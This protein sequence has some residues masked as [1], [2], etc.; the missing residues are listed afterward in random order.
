MYRADWRRAIHGEF[1]LRVKLFKICDA[2]AA[3]LFAFECY[4]VVGLSAENTARRILLK[5]NSV[6]LNK[7]L[8][9]VTGLYIH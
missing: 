4:D 7:D 5:H 9:T 2:V 1:L 8:Y 3:N 6:L